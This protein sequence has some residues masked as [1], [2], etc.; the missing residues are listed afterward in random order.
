MQKKKHGNDQLYIIERRKKANNSNIEIHILT[1]KHRKD[2]AI[3][4]KMTKN[5]SILG[6]NQTNVK[7]K[8]GKS[9]VKWTT[10]WYSIMIAGFMGSSC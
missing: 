4:D 5:Q 1:R 6:F 10:P 7:Q 3:Y 9:T 2:Q 8:K